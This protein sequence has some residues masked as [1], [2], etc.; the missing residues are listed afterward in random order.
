MNIKVTT[1]YITTYGCQMNYSDSERI[2][3]ILIK[4]NL[5]PAKKKEK[6]DV[7]IYNSCSVRQKAEDRIFGLGKEIRKL[8]EKRKNHLPITILT[9]CIARRKWQNDIKNDLKQQKNLRFLK[10]KL[11]FYDFILE[12]KDILQLPQVLKISNSNSEAHHTTD[13]L[14]VIPEY[15]SK[16]QAYVPISTGCNHF[17]T[18]CVVPYARGRETNRDPNEIIYEVKNLVKAGYKDIMLVG[19]S[20]NR[21][22]NPKIKNL[23][24]NK[25]NRQPLSDNEMKKILNGK[26]EPQDF[27]QLLQIIDSIKGDFWLEFMS[28]YPN[29]FT[30]ELIDFICNSVNTKEGHIKPHIHLALQSGS[31]KMLKRMNRHY[32]TDKFIKICEKFRNKIPNINLTTDIIVGFPNET[33]EDFKKSLEVAKKLR[34]N[35]IYISEYSPRKGTAADTYTDNISKNIKQKRK[36]ELNDL[37][38]RIALEDNKKMVGRVEKCLVEKIT[39]KGINCRTY[40]SKD[41]KVF[42]K[43]SSK[44]KECQFIDIKIIKATSWNL[45]GVVTKKPKS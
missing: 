20:V 8:K 6:A 22:T 40:N 26:L 43:K 31:N 33:E 7:L 3:S 41:V 21:W 38:G 39:S 35:M 45:E 14:K 18:Y 13:Y 29:Y 34:F 44:I 36:N 32:T 17:C 9:G 24:G 27:L 2:A 5:K 12:T 4:T 28:S 1:F 25:I 15:K 23:N 10:R 42:S 16:F 19:Q 37:L 30:K 11:P